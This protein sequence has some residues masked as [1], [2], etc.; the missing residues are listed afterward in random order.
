LAI[1]VVV[2]VVVAVVESSGLVTTT[3]PAL[4]RFRV[5]RR[6][7]SNQLRDR[8]G[9]IKTEDRNARNSSSE[10]CRTNCPL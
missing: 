2:L 1:P 10:I 3:E 6:S 5:Q 4:A 9:L 7:Q 8:T